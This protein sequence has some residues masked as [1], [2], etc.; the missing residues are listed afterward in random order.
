MSPSDGHVLY[1]LMLGFLLIPAFI[2]S[3]VRHGWGLSFMVFTAAL[4]AVGVSL[5]TP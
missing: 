4:M 5:G 1:H 3:A 2:A